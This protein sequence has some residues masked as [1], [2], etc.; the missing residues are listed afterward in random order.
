MPYSVEAHIGSLE[1]FTA[2]ILARQSSMGS[3]DWN[4]AWGDYNK[5]DFGAT[6]P[7]DKDGQVTSVNNLAASVVASLNPSS[8]EAAVDS[9][10][11]RFDKVTG[12]FKRA[13][14][15]HQ[16]VRLSDETLTIANGII[17]VLV[18]MAAREIQGGEERNRV[19]SRLAG[20]LAVMRKAIIMTDNVSADYV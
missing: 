6:V 13:Y 1:T 5:I 16:G 8:R 11:A 17:D 10:G 9:I 20:R 3:G 18:P 4:E 19:V 15:E 14:A 2:E 7:P 12:N